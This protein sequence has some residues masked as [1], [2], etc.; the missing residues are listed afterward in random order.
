M[1]HLITQDSKQI[2]KLK[3]K[4]SEEF[5]AEELLRDK[6]VK[7]TP[8]SVST[9]SL[10]GKG[11]SV[12][13]AP[14]TEDARP[15]TSVTPIGIPPATKIVP[16]LAKEVVVDVAEASPGIDAIENE[17]LTKTCIEL[18]SVDD[19]IDAHR[20]K[21]DMDIIDK[22]ELKDLRESKK[23]LSLE[24]GEHEASVATET[25]CGAVINLPNGLLD[26]QILGVV[27]AIVQQQNCIGIIPRGGEVS[28]IFCPMD[29]R[30]KSVVRNYPRGGSPSKKEEVGLGRLTCAEIMTRAFPNRW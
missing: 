22:E 19:R 17:K 26:D 16:S 14:K 5:V 21:K 18:A 25:G 4:A 10:E 23:R 11:E 2:K 12:D 7:V 15:G 9:M 3:Q 6:R 20:S 8:Q 28:R 13:E 1:T 30:T 29:V 27:D 24:V